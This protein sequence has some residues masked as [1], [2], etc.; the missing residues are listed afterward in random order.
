[1]KYGDIY[2]D[3]YVSYK[4]SKDTVILSPIG[5][6]FQDTRAVICEDGRLYIVCAYLNFSGKNIFDKDIDYPAKL[7]QAR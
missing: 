6:L 2:G 1:M 4:E 3:Y 7:E 5:K